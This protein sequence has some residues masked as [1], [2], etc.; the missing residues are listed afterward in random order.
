MSAY[1]KMAISKQE[2]K[3]LKSK[4]QKD[5]KDVKTITKKVATEYLGYNAT[6]ND[7]YEFL[8]DLYDYKTHLKSVKSKAAKKVHLRKRRTALASALTKAREYIISR[9]KKTI[10]AI[11]HQQFGIRKYEI[12]YSS[13]TTFNIID[14][15][16]RW[17]KLKQKGDAVRVTINSVDNGKGVNMSPTENITAEQIYAMIE[18]IIT[19]YESFDLIHDVVITVRFYTLGYLE[20]QGQGG[21][22]LPLFLQN[23]TK[24]IG[25]IIN[26]DGLCGQRALYLSTLDLKQMEKV[27]G[28]A[29]RKKKRFTKEVNKWLN[30]NNLYKKPMNVFEDFEKFTEILDAKIFIVSDFMKIIHT[31]SN[32]EFNN[33]VYIYYDMRKKAVGHYH[34]IKDMAKLVDDRKGQ[35]TWCH[36]CL[37]RMTKIGFKNHKCQKKLECRKCFKCKEVFKTNEDF[38]AHIHLMKKE[39]KDDNSCEDCG[40]MCSGD[41]CAEKHFKICSNKCKKGCP[42][43]CKHSWFYS[44]CYKKRFELG[45]LY[46]EDGKALTVGECWGRKKDR[47]IHNC[48]HKYCSTCDEIR[49]RNHRCIIPK[50]ELKDQGLVDFWGFDFES[51]FDE[52][53]RHRVLSVGVKNSQT[54]EELYWD[55]L[56]SKNPL[57]DFMNFALKHKNVTFVAHNMKGYDGIIIKQRMEELEDM[58]RPTKI[59][60]A[61]A[62]IMYM[63]WKSV[64]FM[65]SLN[66]IQGTLDSFTKTFNLKETK[67][68]YPYLFNKDSENPAGLNYIGEIPHPKYFNP[69]F[70]KSGTPS[71]TRKA[72]KVFMKWWQ[73]KKDNKY[74]WVHREETKNYNMEDVRLLVAGL[75]IYA[76]E[77]YA[78]TGID[79]L[80]KPTIA[81]YA[82]S[83]FLTNHYN[84]E[85]NPIA[86][87][88][89]YEYE[90]VKRS[91]VGGRTEAIRNY[92]KWEDHEIANGIGGRY[93]DIQSLYPTVQFYDELPIGLPEITK[94]VITNKKKITQIVNNTYGFIECDIKPNKNLFIPT[95]VFKEQGKLVGTLEDRENVVFH[96]T[97]LK[98]A[99]KQGYEI[100]QIHEIHKY[101][102][103]KDIFKSYVSTFLEIKVNASQLPELDE[104]AYDEWVKYHEQQFGFTPQP[105]YN[106]GKRAI[107]K[108][109]LNSLWG[110]FTQKP[111]M[112]Q[113]DYIH[114]SESKKW[115]KLL[116]QNMDGLIEIKDEHLSGNDYLFV[117]YV[118][119]KKD[120]NNTLHK[121]NIA[122]GA[123]VT[124]NAR[125]RLYDELKQLKERVIYHDTDS[126]IYEHNPELYNVKEGMYLGDW[127]SET[128]DKL[129]EEIVTTGAKSYA[130]KI[131]GV[132]ECCKCKGISLN[133]QNLDAINFA[134]MKSLVFKNQKELVADG[135]LHF[136][137]SNNS[138]ITQNDFTKS[139]KFEIKRNEGNNFFTYPINYIGTVY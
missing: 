34:Y 122:L 137:K 100:T 56:N 10:Q 3:F 75:N 85:N 66:H 135:N 101:S 27:L 13:G 18:K 39:W 69:Q 87:L 97:E 72:H 60:L 89:K 118:D 121:T 53:D 4:F 36:E 16:V 71:K 134:G 46:K 139:V 77:G 108:L 74:L 38:N 6:T 116:Q 70:I 83:V 20:W 55:K 131:G 67:G 128:G 51:E 93:V 49:P 58:Q 125:M 2:K 32:E 80:R 65:D 28:T 23:K 112:P 41:K 81:S 114:V 91:F 33:R 17:I 19:S 14:D 78:L 111:C 48:Q 109:M 44:C 15:L 94:N 124:A 99:L 12:E 42:Q 132:V 117:N 102:T 138:I 37:K 126:V 29:D 1:N 50:K 52:K 45:K 82:M 119:I 24:S 133:M 110:K 54:G 26:N 5:I 79:P 61:G 35:Y 96:T 113:T 25:Q 57:D 123:S 76:K 31:T 68:Y 130:Y 43:S 8:S 22:D 47:D 120:R 129:I 21:D 40:I 106:A 90:F 84:P 9:P 95:L 107:A 63:K 127:E 92:K 104:T 73:E 62:K 59:I 103:S 88:T 115:F 7:L 136:K 30:D 11:A 105:N 64:V 86:V 98:E